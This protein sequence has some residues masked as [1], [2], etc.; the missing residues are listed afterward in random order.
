MHILVGGGTG[1]I[2]RHLVKQLTKSGHQVTIVSRKSGQN[3]ITWDD[4]KLGA[5]DNVQARM[6]AFLTSS[7]LAQNVFA[8]IL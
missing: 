5:P 1:F 6:S 7:I 2:G 3:R 4:L 8:A